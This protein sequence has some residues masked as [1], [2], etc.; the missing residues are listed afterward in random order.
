MKICLVSDQF[1][2][3]S[4][5]LGTYA[6]QLSQ[7]LA[8]A[9]HGI[10]L[11]TFDSKPFDQP[12]EVIRLNQLPFHQNHA[13]WYF[14]SA[15]FAKAV[16]RKNKEKHFDLIHF[17]DAR[18]SYFFLKKK[19]STSVV[20]T[21]NDDYFASS[22]R[23]LS[24]YKTHYY[25]WFKRWAYYQWV[26]SLEKK[27]LPRLAHLITCSNSVKNSMARH[28]QISDLRMTAVYYGVSAVSGAALNVQSKQETHSIVF[29][30]SNPQRKGLKLLLEALIKVVPHFPDLA[31]YVV[32]ENA[33]YSYFKNVVAMIPL[34]RARVNFLGYQSNK[35]VRQLLQQSSLYVMPS[36]M[37]G[38]AISFLEA[39]LS[40]TPV[41]G[42]RAGSTQELIEDGKN[43]FLVDYRDSNQLADKIIQLF[44]DCSLYE[45]FQREGLKTASQF[46]PER[47]ASA[48][49]AVYRKMVSVS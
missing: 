8:G 25:D 46:T 16:H 17:L 41:I 19:V 27:C 43:G 2:K 23:D 37:E 33:A 42:G 10:T 34:L 18:E 48:T 13:T 14:K 36:I 35:E 40:G 24:F 5:G 20:G 39:M 1:S 47:M 26:Y 12:F 11:I 32:G 15:A 7:S 9:G 21:M 44:N 38:F 22:P 29:I 31:L 28:Y 4:S 30:G 3:F 49:L 6:Y 45:Q